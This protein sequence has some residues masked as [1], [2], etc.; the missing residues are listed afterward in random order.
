MVCPKCSG[1]LEPRFSHGIEV[2]VCVEC[3]GAWLDRP[4]IDKLAMRSEPVVLASSDA[5]ESVQDG[6]PT[7]APPKARKSENSDDEKKSSKKKSKKKRHKG[8]ADE[9][10]DILEDVL[11]FDD[12]FEDILDF[13]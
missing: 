2:D 5:A 6:N 7:P 11:D 8:W 13:D 4:E 12:L 9:L 10:E 3:G 1:S